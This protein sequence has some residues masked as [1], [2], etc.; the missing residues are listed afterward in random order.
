MIIHGDS[1]ASIFYCNDHTL[2]SSLWS[3]K[4]DIPHMS[5]KLFGVFLW[6][7]N[8]KGNSIKKLFSNEN[9]MYFSNFSQIILL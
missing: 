8:N 1:C 7:K 3:L 4:S 2:G 9:W 6:M 5:L